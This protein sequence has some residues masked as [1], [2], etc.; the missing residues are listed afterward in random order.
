M[1]TT[2]LKIPEL[3]KRHALSGAQNH[4]RAVTRP[5]SGSLRRSFRCSLREL[6]GWR[7]HRHPMLPLASA[8]AVGITI[9][10]LLGGLGGLCDTPLRGG[11]WILVTLTITVLILW[12]NSKSAGPAVVLVFLPIAACSHCL[13]ELAYE[14][15]DI[16]LLV[17]S[18]EQ[19]AVL[20]GVI[21]RPVVLRRHPLA[22]WRDQ[23]GESPWQTQFELSLN[24]IRLG[25]EMQPCRGRVLVIVDGDC[26]ERR[27]GDEVRILGGICA[28]TA[29]TN[30]GEPDRRDVYRQRQLHARANCDA[31]EQVIWL[32]WRPTWAQYF[33]SCIAKI[34]TRGRQSL[35]RHMDET[36]GALAAALVLGQR[37]FVDESTRDLLLVTGTAHLLSVSGLHL[38]IVVAIAG[39]IATIARFPLP[40]KIVWILLICVLYTG[41]TGARPPVVRAAILVGTLMLALWMRRPGQPINTLA[42]AAMILMAVNPRLLFNMGVQLSFLA[43]TTL[44]TC[45]RQRG[46][47]SDSVQAAVQQEQR[48]NLLVDQSRSPVGRFVRAFGYRLGQA[49][50]FSGCVTAISMPLVWQHFHVVTPVSIATNV[51]LGPVLFLALASGVAT[52]VVG[53]LF[54]PGVIYLAAVC[55]WSLAGMQRIIELA[56]SLPGGHHWLPSPPSW[57]VA[58]FYV[59]IAATMWLARSRRSSLI[60][61][62]WICVWLCLAWWMAT[63][64]PRL[65]KGSMEATFVD[66]GH[67][68]CVVLRFSNDEVWLYDCGR[69]GNDTY[70]SRGI[71]SVLWSFSKFS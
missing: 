19:S 65:A 17:G 70:S 33:F 16:L 39:W 23:R 14:R 15:A 57:W 62:G 68:T 32:G 12:R 27:P 4:S 1:G 41:I 34:A 5:F 61:Y 49:F 50:W 9:D 10:S 40:A 54:E 45:S 31:T 25:R 24:R 11:F 30:P 69:L 71:D 53:F 56:A 37:E 60:R 35:M 66:V 58:T 26:G 20:E 7:V 42:L 48:L 28:F 2:I 47:R 21:D 51:I 63:S 38:A 18:V 6:L 44:L 22:E 43:V 59:V 3:R 64:Q 55:E 8:A 67:G 46:R 29:P 36:T 13:H 52:V